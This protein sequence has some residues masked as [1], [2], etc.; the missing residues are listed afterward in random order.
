[1]FKAAVVT[2]TLGALKVPPPVLIAARS[3][4]CSDTKPIPRPERPFGVG[5]VT[6]WKVQRKDALLQD[7]TPCATSE[8]HDFR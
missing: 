6:L 5:C 7:S 1:M 4:I 8:I 3:A 2:K